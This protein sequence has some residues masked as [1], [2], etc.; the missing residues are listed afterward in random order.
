MDELKLK[1]LNK[2]WTECLAKL[3]RDPERSEQLLAQV[4]DRLTYARAERLKRLYSKLCDFLSADLNNCPGEAWPTQVRLAKALAWSERDVRVYLRMLEVLGLVYTNRTRHRADPSTEA[5]LR[6]GDH[7][8][9]PARRT[10]IAE[11][12]A[13]YRRK[14]QITRKLRQPAVHR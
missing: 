8:V 5:L 2:W 13:R 14:Q 1:E 12:D 3:G 10:S 4:P 11:Y 6:A 7:R 9:L